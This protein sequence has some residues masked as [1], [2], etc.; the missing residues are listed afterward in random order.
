VPGSGQSES[1]KRGLIAGDLAV[2]EREK[3]IPDLMKLEKQIN[4]LNSK[5][6]QV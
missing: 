5:I 3:K 2:N 6:Y 4:K 1:Y